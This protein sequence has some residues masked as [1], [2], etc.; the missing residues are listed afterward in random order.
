MAIYAFP[1]RFIFP[2]GAVAAEFSPLVWETQTGAGGG[3]DL[4]PVIPGDHWG[5]FGV[6]LSLWGVG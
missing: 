5:H 1:A 4:I 3:C 2:L 6:V